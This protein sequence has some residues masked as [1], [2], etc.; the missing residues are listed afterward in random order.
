MK[1]VSPQPLEAVDIPAAQRSFVRVDIDRKVEIIG[2][3]WYRN[4]VGRKP[5]GLKN[6]QAFHDQDVGLVDGTRFTGYDVVGKVRVDRHGHAT[7]SG[8]DV[9]QECQQCRPVVALRKSLALHQPLALQH[10]VRVEEP[11]G[12]DEFDLRRVGPAA[13]K[14]PQHPR[15]GRFSDRHRAGDPDHETA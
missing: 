7:C 13:Q 10:S 4:P 6:V 3:E 2:D 15:G 8:L 11:V 5:G 14:C 9:G 12:R 1:A